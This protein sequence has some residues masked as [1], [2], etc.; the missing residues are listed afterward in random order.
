[1]AGKCGELSGNKQKV[2]SS[3]EAS[4]KILF[5]IT[6][7]T[8]NIYC[9]LR[10][11]QAL[12]VVLGLGKIWNEIECECYKAKYDMVADLKQLNPLFGE[13]NKLLVFLANHARG[14]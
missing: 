7:V 8:P 4:K 10:L 1:M 12:C 11:C 5:Y 2:L 13:T 9:V 14:V 6:S 3:G